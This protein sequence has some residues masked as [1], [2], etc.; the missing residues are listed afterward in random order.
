VTVIRTLLVC[1]ELADEKLAPETDEAIGHA[2]V[3]LAR[4]EVDK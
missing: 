2:I 4:L 3:L 1:D